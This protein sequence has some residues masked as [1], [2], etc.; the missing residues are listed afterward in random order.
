MT[1]RKLIF[2]CIVSIGLVG[3]LLPFLVLILGALSSESQIARLDFFAPKWETFI[4]NASEV[5]FGRNNLFGAITNSLIVCSLM[6]A[7]QVPS[8]ILCAYGFAFFSFP[9]KKLLFATLVGSFLIPAVSTVVPLFLI[10]TSLGLKG[11]ALGVLLPYVLFSPY[12]VVLLRERFES[13]PSELIDQS[14]LDGLSDWANLVKIV[15]PVSKSFIWLIS[16]V[17]FVSMWSAFLWPRV[18]GAG[19]WT[20]ATVSTAALQGQYD[21][22]WNLVLTATLIILIP[23]VLVFTIS[24]KHLV[25]NYL[26]ELDV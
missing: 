2:G 8:S 9:A 4:G 17:T 3:T 6:V 15:I 13:I 11:S 19:G 7:I 10:A 23:A 25:R 5:L 12:A 24:N 20:T 26:E 16:L 14:K 1:S 18:I 21:S 22:N